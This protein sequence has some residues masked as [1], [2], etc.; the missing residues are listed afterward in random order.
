[1]AGSPGTAVAPVTRDRIDVPGPIAAGGVSY[2]PLP[3]RRALPSPEPTPE[4][5]DPVRVVI[6]AIGVDSPLIRLGL[7][8]DRT[9]EVP[10]DHRIAGWYTGSAVAGEP[11]PSVIVGHVDSYLGPGIFFSLSRLVPGDEV[12]V[13]GKGRTLARFVV[14]RVE[15]H[16]KDDFPTQKVYGALPYPGL[17]LITCGGVFNEGTGHYLDNVI[18]FARLAA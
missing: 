11:G 9:L 6:P 18:A 4:Y 12:L 2:D 10:E 13:R 8:P 5:G 7:N 15:R 1:M 14:Q 3:P 16:A 17:R